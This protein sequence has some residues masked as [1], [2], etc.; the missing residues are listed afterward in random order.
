MNT[1]AFVANAVI[2]LDCPACD[3]T[4]LVDQIDLDDQI[5]CDSCL[6]AFTQAEPA[7]AQLEALAA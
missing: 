5:R 1:N 3:S 4:I 7:A 2:A 6:V